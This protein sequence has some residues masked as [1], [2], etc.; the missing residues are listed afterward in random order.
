MD[1]GLFSFPSE[2][3]LVLFFKEI[4]PLLASRGFPLT[5]FFTT[6]EQLKIIIPKAD[7][8]PVKTMQFKD[9]NCLTNTLGMTWCSRDDC[10]HFD[11]AFADTS[12][13]K[14]TSYFF[15]FSAR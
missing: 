3:D 9:D 13:V 5:K 10:F 6:S 12:P 14:L 8:L 7:L 2:A 1:D 11:C 15:S 4:V